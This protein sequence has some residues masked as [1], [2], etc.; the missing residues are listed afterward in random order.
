MFCLDVERPLMA[1]SIGRTGSSILTIQF[2]PDF[3]PGFDFLYGLPP[4]RQRKP[5]HWRLFAILLQLAST[6][7]LEH[8]PV[9]TLANIR[10]FA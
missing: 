1:R 5:C 2:V 4:L 9:T 8:R 3:I 6:H 7:S 10:A